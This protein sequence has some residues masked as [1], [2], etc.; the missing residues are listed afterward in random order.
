MTGLLAHVGMTLAKK[1]RERNRL[2]GHAFVLFYKGTLVRVPQVETDTPEEIA[3]RAMQMFDTAAVNETSISDNVDV[4]A[5]CR[6]PMAKS[7]YSFVRFAGNNDIYN[8]T[9]SKNM[10]KDSPELS[11][12]FA[13]RQRQTDFRI[14]VPFFVATFDGKLFMDR[15]LYK[16]MKL[17]N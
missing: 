2:S 5:F 11:V 1:Y 3:G 7:T 4:I 14:M 12:L 17:W 16:Q 15:D 10:E 9:L 8:V 13:T 6:N